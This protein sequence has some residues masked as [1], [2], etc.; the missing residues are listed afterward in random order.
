MKSVPVLVQF[1]HETAGSL[2]SGLVVSF[3]LHLPFSD[4]IRIHPG[5]QNFLRLPVLNNSGGDV[6]F[7]EII[8]AVC[9]SWCSIRIEVRLQ[10]AGPQNLIALRSVYYHS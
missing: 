2:P 6:S 7:G 5:G 3:P 8:E 10:S 9:R 4:T 1:I